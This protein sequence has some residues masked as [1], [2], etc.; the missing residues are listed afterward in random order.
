MDD[1]ISRKELKKRIA[2]YHNRL[3]PRY[4]SKLVDAE[5]LD[6]QDIV[7]EQHSVEAEPVQH[8]RWV[9]MDDTF[10]RWKCSECGAIESH[11][12]WEYCHCG[13]KMDAKEDDHG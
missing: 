7:D 4:I 6:I 11:S 1:L 2:E 8:G 3:K 13:A 10:A 5:I 9:R 12:G